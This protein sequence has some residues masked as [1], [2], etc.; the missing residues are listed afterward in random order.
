MPITALPPHMRENNSMAIGKGTDWDNWIQ[1]FIPQHW[2]AFG[3]NVDETKEK[4]T[5]IPIIVLPCWFRMDTAR[6]NI[7]KISFVIDMPRPVTWFKVP[8]PIPVRAKWRRYPKVLL[9]YNVTRWIGQ[10]D[11][12]RLKVHTLEKKWIFPWENLDEQIHTVTE[13][14]K[15]DEKT[16]TYE[17]TLKDHGPSPIQYWAKTGF[18]ITWPLHFAFQAQWKWSKVFQS[19][20]KKIFGRIGFRWDSFDDFTDGPAAFIGGSFN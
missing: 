17:R 6:F 13:E 4:W 7:W 3:P 14:R 8:F 10:N 5:F 12:T 18:Q 16:Y 1:A 11:K 20:K 2:W 15:G 9:G 19:F